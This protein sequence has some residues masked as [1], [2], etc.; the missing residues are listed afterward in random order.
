MWFGPLFMVLLLVALVAGAVALVRG[1]GAGRA[2]T[3]T[4]ILDE[5]FARGEI[6]K[7]DYEERRR[8]LGA[9]P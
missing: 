8:I 9:R 5:R 3:P 2:Q 7:E 1:A 4:Q 6:T